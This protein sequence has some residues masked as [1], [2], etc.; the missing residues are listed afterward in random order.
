MYVS[1]YF[2]KGNFGELLFDFVGLANLNG[3]IK[4]VSGIW[5]WKARVYRLNNIKQKVT[6]VY[7]ML[8]FYTILKCPKLKNPNESDNLL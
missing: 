6:K 7:N 1:S 2:F 8:Y 3:K 4:I 5:I